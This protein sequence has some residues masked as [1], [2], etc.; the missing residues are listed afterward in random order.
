M[1]LHALLAAMALGIGCLVPAFSAEG[2][3]PKGKAAKKQQ[4]PQEQ[5]EKV[6]QVVVKKS[7]PRL[8]N[9]YGKLGLTAEQKNEIYTIQA[10]HNGQIDA[11]EEQIRQLKENRDAEIVSVLSDMQREK[12]KGL[13]DGK[14]KKGLAEADNEIMEKA[15]PEE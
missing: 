3:K 4:E 2:V 15:Q 7:S 13:V 1:K 5:Q 14:K 10:R 8:P 12:L 11:L 6:Q 9:N